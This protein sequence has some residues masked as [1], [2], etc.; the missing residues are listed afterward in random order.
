MPDF[1]LQRLPDAPL[2]HGIVAGSPRDRRRLKTATVGRWGARIRTWKCYFA[3]CPLKCRPNSPADFGTHRDRR[4]FARSLRKSCEAAR[5]C[6][7]LA[8]VR[9]NP[10]SG[11]KFMISTVETSF[12]TDRHHD[13]HVR[14]CE[15]FRMPAA[16]EPCRGLGRPAYEN[17]HM[18]G[19]ASASIS[20]FHWEDLSGSPLNQSLQTGDLLLEPCQFVGP[21]VHR[22]RRAS[23]DPQRDRAATGI[24]AIAT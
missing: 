23:S 3:K 4:L 16:H 14:F 8:P 19:S 21:A 10:A 11:P 5:R 13:S 20:S 15:G 2:T 1:S 9:Y 6:V 17:L 24:A 12:Q 22:R 18:S 7:V